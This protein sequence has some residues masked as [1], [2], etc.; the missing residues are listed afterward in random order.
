MA[1]Q[2]CLELEY[3]L[4]EMRS[5]SHRVLGWCAGVSL[6]QAWN[7]V[8]RSGTRAAVL[9]GNQVEHLA[10]HWN[11]TCR[12]WQVENLDVAMG[13]G[14]LEVVKQVGQVLADV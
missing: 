12:I 1:V 7:F 4:D 9:M 13:T 11:R 6:V 2:L 3:G 8:G 10:E 14:G 5:G